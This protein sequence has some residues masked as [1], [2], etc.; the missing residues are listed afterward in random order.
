MI[1]VMVAVA[2][3]WMATQCCKDANFAKAQLM[4]R[5]QNAAHA[6]VM[7]MMIMK[8]LLN[9]FQVFPA[10]AGGFPTAKEIS[11]D[12]ADGKQLFNIHGWQRRIAFISDS[13]QSFIQ[14]VGQSFHLWPAFNYFSDHLNYS[15][16]QVQHLRP[17][18]ISDYSLWNLLT[19]I[20]TCGFTNISPTYK[21]V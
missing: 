4:K 21:S 19:E 20:T 11:G 2:W 9:L 6:L 3:K 18:S 5:F 12:V 15:S 14:V 10:L 17:L 13:T 8:S 16:Q 1:C 7:T